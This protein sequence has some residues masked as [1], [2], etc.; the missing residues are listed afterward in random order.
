MLSSSE[1]SYVHTT[2]SIPRKKHGMNFQPVCLRLYTQSAFT[3]A[4]KYR[5]VNGKGYGI[6][7][8]SPYQCITEIISS[9]K[10]PCQCQHSSV[11]FESHPGYCFT[12]KCDNSIALVLLAVYM[13]NNVDNTV[14]RYM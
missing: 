3:F 12:Q 13:M 9:L 8:Y 2:Y 7:G 4:T 10:C 6:T 11:R 14:F 1:P 5:F